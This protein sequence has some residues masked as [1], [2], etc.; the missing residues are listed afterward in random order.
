M[1][2]NGLLFV[3]KHIGNKGPTM[4][5]HIHW[6]FPEIHH[7]TSNQLR[8]IKNN[9]EKK[10]I[11]TLNTTNDEFHFDSGSRTFLPHVST[12]PRVEKQAWTETDSISKALGLVLCCYC[13]VKTAFQTSGPVSKSISHR[14]PLDWKSSMQ[15]NLFC[16]CNYYCKMAFFLTGTVK[17]KVQILVTA[18]LN[19]RK[20]TEADW[21]WN[22]II[23]SFSE[24]QSA[25]STILL[26]QTGSR[27]R[28]AWIL[29]STPDKIKH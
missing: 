6:A 10:Q 26:F 16:Y 15:K 11:T 14:A 25:S 4:L 29:L 2:I 1:K 21:K 28:E 20:F 18:V 22:E 5:G 17:I 3:V 27:R 13:S 12:E 9:A 23:K 19:D 8:K 24:E 7:P